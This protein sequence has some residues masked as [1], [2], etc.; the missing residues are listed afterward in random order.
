M[1]KR[2]KTVKTDGLG[3]LEIKKVRAALRLVWQRSHARRLVIQRCT[4]K[5]GFEYCE[6]CGE[7]TPNLK[8]DHIIACGDVDGGFLDRL[9]CPSKRLQGLCKPCHDLKTSRERG[10]KDTGGKRQKKLSFMEN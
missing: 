1:A 4:G 5:D 3:P 2:Q 6:K 7:C 8:V 10:R 9:F